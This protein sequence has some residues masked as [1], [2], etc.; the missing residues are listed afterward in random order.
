MND[1]R[2]TQPSRPDPTAFLAQS[3]SETPRNS[4]CDQLKRLCSAGHVA[5]MLLWLYSRVCFVTYERS[6]TFAFS[7]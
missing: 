5:K 6:F 2:Q 1:V 4:G 3:T 7:V